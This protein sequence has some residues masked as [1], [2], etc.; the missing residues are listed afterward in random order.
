MIVEFLDKVAEPQNLY[1]VLHLET[2]ALLS[3]L[4]AKALNQNHGP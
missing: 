2:I 1:P 4:L 3:S